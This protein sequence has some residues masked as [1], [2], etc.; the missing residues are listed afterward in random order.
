MGVQEGISVKPLQCRSDYF[1][2]AAKVLHCQKCNAPRKQYSRLAVFNEKFAEPGPGKR[3]YAALSY[4]G[5]NVGQ[6]ENLAST[7]FS[8]KHVEDE[9]HEESY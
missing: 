3:D 4:E 6:G 9:R 1:S 2:R 8:L 7:L 5:I